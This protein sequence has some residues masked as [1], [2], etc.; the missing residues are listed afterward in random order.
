MK[1][2]NLNLR[3]YLDPE[4]NGY[5]VRFKDAHG[6]E[7]EVGEISQQEVRDLNLGSLLDMSDY[8]L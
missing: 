3:I 5:L 6:E 7:C 4:T 1:P 8:I 2:I